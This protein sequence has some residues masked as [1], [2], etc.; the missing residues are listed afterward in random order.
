MAWPETEAAPVQNS[1]CLAVLS[2]AL[3][4]PKPQMLSSSLLIHWPEATVPDLF[5]FTDLR[6]SAYKLS[7]NCITSSGSLLRRLSS[8]QC[9]QTSLLPSSVH[10][11]LCFMPLLILYKSSQHPI[12]PQNKGT[13]THQGPTQINLFKTTGYEV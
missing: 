2:S 1:Q 10:G 8:N 6:V 4:T 7:P 12:L 5:L 3:V 13:H 11:H 9:M